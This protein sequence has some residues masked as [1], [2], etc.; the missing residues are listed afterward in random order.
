LGESILLPSETPAELEQSTL[1]RMASVLLDEFADF[2]GVDLAGEMSHGGRVV[3]S[4][5]WVAPSL[6]ESLE[7]QRF[8][9]PSWRGH[10]L[11]TTLLTSE[12]LVVETIRPDGIALMHP[13]STIGKPAY[14]LGLRSII[15]IPLRA[16]RRPLGTL[17]LAALHTSE[18]FTVDDLAV[19]SLIASAFIAALSH[20][21]NVELSGPGPDSELLWNRSPVAMIRVDADGRILVVNPAALTMF[22]VAEDELVGSRLRERFN[23]FDVE[24][25]DQVWGDSRRVTDNVLA[26]PDNLDSWM[27]GDV[28]GAASD[29]RVVDGQGE[30]RWIAL[31]IEEVDGTEDEQEFVCFMQDIAPSKALEQQVAH[32]VFH[33]SL[34]GLA[35]SLAFSDRLMAALR[36]PDRR[37]DSVAVIV[38][39]LERFRAFNERLGHQRGD[40][41]LIAVARRLQRSIGSADV[42]ARL[43]SDEFGILCEQLDGEGAAKAVAEQIVDLLNAPIP[44]SGMQVMV[45]VGIGVATSHT[46]TDDPEQE[47]AALLANARLAMKSAKAQTRSRFVVHDPSSSQRSALRL[48][49]EMELASLDAQQLGVAYQPIFGTTPDLVVSSLPIVGVEVMSRWIHPERGILDADVFSEIAEQSGIVVPIGAH[50]AEV[51]LA[52]FAIWC[53][54]QLLD[55]TAT[56]H[57]RVSTCEV[58]RGAVAATITALA[59]DFH[60]QPERVTVEIDSRA[61]DLAPASTLRFTEGLAS[62]GFGLGL[63][64]AGSNGTWPQ[65][66]GE[67][68]F[69][70]IKLASRVIRDD[71]DPRSRDWLRAVVGGLKSQHALV[72]AKGVETARHIDYAASLGVGGFQ[73]RALASPL[74]A[75][76]ATSFLVARG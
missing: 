18:P 31:T 58:L 66:L 61:F 63:D 44:I 72:V 51:G 41:L 69:S 23:P 35:N 76:S 13:E 68:R 75:D 29:L 2:V 11:T 62:Q 24:T 19:A 49:L 22:C 36:A 45:H 42:L 7:A 4:A 12:A 20:N 48:A 34:T 50:A 32:T 37:E 21:A 59:R 10:P 16:G 25:F 8:T 47:A 33:D 52:T 46:L 55:L 73:G 26:I 38:V 6:R 9:Q 27:S 53:E 43:N 3:R 15:V 67:G 39:D 71:L 74:D 17:V 56:L 5:E 40:E 54:Q 1:G 14:E 64:D 57:L 65:Y 28:F 60:V 70:V 30:D